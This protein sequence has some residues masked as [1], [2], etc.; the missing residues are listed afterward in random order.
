M[1]T[2]NW[3]FSYAGIDLPP[4]DQNGFSP[5]LQPIDNAER[6]A[7]GDMVLQPVTMKRTLSATWSMLSGDK[8]NKIFAALEANRKGTLVFF[9]ISK[10]SMDAMQVYYGAGPKVN[11]FRYDDNLVKQKW[12][13]LSINFIEM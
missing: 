2:Q 4:P 12:T 13:A 11:F 1:A 8:M 7:N 6:N 10:G 5:V 3:K 9:N